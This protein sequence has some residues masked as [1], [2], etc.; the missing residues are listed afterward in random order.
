MEDFSELVEV[1]LDFHWIHVKFQTFR[2]Y[3]RGILIISTRI[4][5]QFAVAAVMEIID[6]G[7]GRVD[8]NFLVRFRQLA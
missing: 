7:W 6:E 2:P 1:N 4:L 5:S 8:N 3:L